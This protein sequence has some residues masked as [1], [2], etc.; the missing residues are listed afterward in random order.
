MSTNIRLSFIPGFC[1]VSFYL[2]KLLLEQLHF[3]SSSFKHLLITQCIYIDSAL[4]KNS[5]LLLSGFYFLTENSRP[6]SENKLREIERYTN[7]K[8][9]AYLFK[10]E[11]E[12]VREREGERE[13]NLK[14]V[15]NAEDF[16]NL[17]SNFK[18]LLR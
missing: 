3:M 2:S 9:Y 16:R 8:I 4:K 10:I 15:L 5:P 13:F 6:N 14:R 17:Y 18:F 12:K 7:K 11:R 1:S